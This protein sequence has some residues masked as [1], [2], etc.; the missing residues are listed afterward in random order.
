M[1][2]KSTFALSIFLF[3]LIPAL[4]A[5]QVYLV[6]DLGTLPG[7]SFSYAAGVNNLGQVAGT[8]QVVNSFS[9]LVIHAFLWTK[10][11]G[12]Q[13]LGT[14]P[15]LYDD[16]NFSSWANGVNDL[17]L[18]VGGSWFDPINNHAFAWSH[19]GG[20]QDLGTAPGTQCSDAQSINL[21]G[22]V[23]GTAYEEPAIGEQCSLGHA[24]LWT[25]AGGMQL[26]GHLPDGLYSEASSINVFGQVVGIADTDEIYPPNPGKYDAFLWTRRD[27]MVDL[28]AWTPA[29]INDLGQVVGSGPFQSNSSQAV[30]WAR[31]R[32]LR[33]LGTLPG[34]KS[35]SAAAIDDFDLVVGQST[36]AGSPYTPHAM[37]W[38]QHSGMWDLNDLIS[39]NSGW[40]LSSATGINI[41]G[42]VVGY[43]TI[44]GQEHAFL[45][46]PKLRLKKISSAAT[47]A[48]SRAKTER[49]TLP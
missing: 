48:D 7:G 27:G 33:D 19:T 8:S 13:D 29:A 22:Q 40:V 17:G 44:N 11:G 10:S 43:G 20:M 1:R 47:A 14:L 36:T 25:N 28:G 21:F 24:F 34:G 9:A 35:S 18:V 26:L 41:L 45:L 32:G 6:T 5:A 39:A 12:M 42:Q 2:A 38:S 16:P 4:A 49:H 15:D 31:H 3:C 30:L 23:V 37:L 46:T